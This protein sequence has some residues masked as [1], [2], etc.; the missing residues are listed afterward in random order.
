LSL[1]TGAAALVRL[2][3]LLPLFPPFFPPLFRVIAAPPRPW[4]G[5]RRL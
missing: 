1:G 4:L 3:F 2:P 5:D